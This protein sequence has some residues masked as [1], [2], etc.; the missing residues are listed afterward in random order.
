LAAR[1][2]R[3]DIVYV[4]LDLDRDKLRRFRQQHRGARALA[5]DATRCPIQTAS[6]DAVMA[7]KVTHHLDDAQLAAMV[8]EAARILR[9]GGTLIIVDAVRAKRVAS[10]LLWSLDR[11]AYPRT[12]DAIQSAIASAFTPAHVEDF[13]V[14][15]FHQFLLYVGRPAAR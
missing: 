13:T 4:C 14:R 1:S 5:A 11:G 8:A 15:F 9:K 3:A 7:V 2:V 12:P 10:R 6:A